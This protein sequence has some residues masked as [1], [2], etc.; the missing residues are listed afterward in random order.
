MSSRTEHYRKVYRFGL[1]PTAARVLMLLRMTHIISSC[2]ASTVTEYRL[3]PFSAEDVLSFC[4]DRTQVCIVDISRENGL[5]SD[6]APTCLVVDDDSNNAAV[7]TATWCQ[8]SPLYHFVFA[9]M[10]YRRALLWVQRWQKKDYYRPMEHN[11]IS[12]DMYATHSDEGNVFDCVL[13]SQPNSFVE[14]SLPSTVS[15]TCLSDD[16]LYEHDGLTYLDASSSLIN[17]TKIG[18]HVLDGCSGLKSLDL[19][20]LKNVTHIGDWFIAGCSGL[21]SLDLSPLSN[22]HHVGC[23]FVSGCS[24]LVTLDISP[25]MAVS[26]IGE[27]FLHRCCALS[28]VGGLSPLTNITSIGR[29]FLNGCSALPSLDLSPLCNVAKIGD[30][31]L[32][33]C[34]SLV[35]LELLPLKNVTKIGDSFLTHCSALTTLD[36]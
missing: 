17:V 35:S 3:C 8:S 14:L 10:A 6:V 24:A 12:L 18:D 23:G 21:T 27:F 22:V 2:G 9:P 11:G 15:A 32:Y 29:Y 16:F 28:S 20:A 31:F 4:I 5:S 26:V 19:T 7:A 34:S 13:S 36:L 30:C 25:L 1:H 33:D